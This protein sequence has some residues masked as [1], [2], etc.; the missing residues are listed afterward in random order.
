MSHA[1][2]GESA[3]R[4]PHARDGRDTAPAQRF[5]HPRGRGTERHGITPDPEC[6]PNHDPR[7]PRGAEN[8][9]PAP[10]PRAGE[11]A[12]LVPRHPRGGHRNA[13]SPP[14]PEALRALLFSAGRGAARD[15]L[16]LAEAESGQTRPDAAFAAADRF[17][18]EAPEPKL[19]FGGADLIA[20][21]VAGGRRIGKTLRAFEALW[22][23]AGLPSEPETLAR[24]LNEA[25]AESARGETPA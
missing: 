22:V 14:S 8:A 17:L 18:A 25:V 15:A 21:G 12:D 3:H 16:A 9:R 7:H 11:A 24:L 20:R 19:P 5:L 4:P 10:P 23:G 1:T 2:S 6:G 13:G